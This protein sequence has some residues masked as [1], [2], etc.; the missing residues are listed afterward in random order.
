MLVNFFFVERIAF[1]KKVFFLSLL[2]R[3]I[4]NLITT[5]TIRFVNGFQNILTTQNISI[6]IHSY[7]PSIR[8]NRRDF[9]ENLL[10]TPGI[11][12]G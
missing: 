4:E 2:Y 1:N 8:M 6:L 11:N 10:P 12:L 3:H 7:N 9:I 5:I